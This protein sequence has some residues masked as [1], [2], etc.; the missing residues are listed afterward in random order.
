MWWPGV[1]ESMDDVW[2]EI[3]KNIK[4]LCELGEN[5]GYELVWRKNVRYQHHQHDLSDNG[6]NVLYYKGRYL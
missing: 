3:H 5:G 1:F 6:C 2:S 4:F